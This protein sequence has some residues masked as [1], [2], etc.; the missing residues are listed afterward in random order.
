MGEVR[1]IVGVHMTVRLI[2]LVAK[3]SNHTSQYHH[4]IRAREVLC[5]K[6]WALTT[7]VKGKQTYTSNYQV[8]NYQVDDNEEANSYNLNLINYI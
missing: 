6:Y 7:N 1:S 8:I 3:I 2:Y 4:A 5:T